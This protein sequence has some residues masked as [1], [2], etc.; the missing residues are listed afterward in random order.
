M[1]ADP[2]AIAPQRHQR[3][4]LNRMLGDWQGH[5]TTAKYVT[6]A[7]CSADTA[8]RDIRELVERGALV[9]NKAGGRSTS[10]RLAGG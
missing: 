10:Y 4:V 3:L 1:H 7:K 9:Q 8:Q 6:L 2:L 5:L